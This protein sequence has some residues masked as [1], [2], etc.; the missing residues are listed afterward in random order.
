[1]ESFAINNQPAGIV[2]FEV[3]IAKTQKTAKKYT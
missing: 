1:M 2:P 3:K